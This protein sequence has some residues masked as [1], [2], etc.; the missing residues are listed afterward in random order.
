MAVDNAAK[1]IF[2][3]KDSCNGNAIPSRCTPE[4]A[5]RSDHAEQRLEELLNRFWYRG[6]TEKLR[7][8]VFPLRYQVILAK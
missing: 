1:V 7:L 5:V 6:Y 8:I 4:S 3:D 2:I